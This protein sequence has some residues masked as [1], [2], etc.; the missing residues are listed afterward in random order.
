M[1]SGLFWSL[2]ILDLTEDFLSHYWIRRAYLPMTMKMCFYLVPSSTLRGRWSRL[3]KLS[4]LCLA[5][6]ICLCNHAGNIARGQDQ[7]LQSKLGKMMMMANEAEKQGNYEE[8]LGLYQKVLEQ[9]PEAFG[10]NSERE[11]AVRNNIAF[12]QSRLGQFANARKTYEDAIVFAESAFGKESP[13]LNSI[14][15]GLAGTQKQA[16]EYEKAEQSLNRVI[17]I[18][19]IGEPKDSKSLAYA[20]NNLADLK[21]LQGDIEGANLYYRESVSSAELAFGKDSDS[22]LEAI[23]E[24][25]KF[26]VNYGDL[27]A[28]VRELIRARD[29]VIKSEKPNLSLLV[30]LRQGLILADIKL[31]NLEAAEVSLVSLID[32]LKKILPVGTPDIVELQIQLAMV[33]KNLKDYEGSEFVIRQAIREMKENG[34][35]KQLALPMVRALS[36]LSDNLSKQGNRTDAQAALVEAISIDRELLPNSKKRSELQWNLNYFKLLDG[37]YAEVEKPIVELH[38][39]FTSNLGPDHP[40]SNSIANAVA[41]AFHGQKKMEEASAWYHRSRQSNFRDLQESLFAQPE[42]LQ[43]ALFENQDKEFLSRTLQFASEAPDNQAIQQRAVEWLANSKG[44]I[45]AVRGRFTEIVRDSVSVEISKTAAII[46][47]NRR[48][49]TAARLAEIAATTDEARLERHNEA[50][51]LERENQSLI[52]RIRGM[53]SDQQKTIPWLSYKDIQ[54]SLGTDRCLI[55]MVKVYSLAP[56]DE[57]TTKTRFMV[58]VTD[59][60][61]TST[62]DLGPSEEIELLTKKVAEQL[63]SAK[64]E[65][66]KLGDQVAERKLQE[67]LKN[68]SSRLLDPIA[69]RIQSSKRWEISLDAELWQIPWAALQ[70]PDGSYAIESHDIEIL[71]GARSLV[72]T[73]RNRVKPSR[74]VLFADPDFGAQA[75]SQSESEDLRGFVVDLNLGFLKELSGTMRDARALAEA[76]TTRAKTEKPIVYAE[77]L[78]TAS[79]FFQIRNPRYLLVAT[80]GFSIPYKGGT[81][82]AADASK[83]IGSGKFEKGNLG[84]LGDPLLRCGLLFAGCNQESGLDVEAMVTARDVLTLDL[85][86][87]EFVLL[88]SCES[89]VGEYRYGAGIASLRQAFLLAGASSVISTQWSISDRYTGLLVESF[90]KELERTGDQVKALAF[91]QR[92]MIRRL[93][94]NKQGS[95]PFYW[96]AFS[97]T[98]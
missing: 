98:R 75:S 73:K 39:E 92:E 18:A 13:K 58:W 52:L 87:C 1:D 44:M 30:R 90:S 26:L 28:A 70:L 72:S 25:G 88:S 22:H 32:D 85:R 20:N 14:L 42:A 19:S 46:D 34:D 65:I 40:L 7:A 3:N 33:R 79:N 81:L 54:N 94:E 69:D 82:D 4:Y 67:S 31:F 61:G 35:I 77:Q 29:I 56:N 50:I 12:V 60:N 78:A 68:L 38:K 6:W 63:S 91:A 51:R 97:V 45:E 16:G 23:I 43:W 49:I 24:Y 48:R 66:D 27:E 80:H 84:S 8:Q 83:L 2:L 96:A 5:C 47:E 37:K 21:T 17:Q 55:D 41:R 89:G 53:L 86:G 76:L 71:T 10:K 64:A 93:K 15:I 9:I 62:Y 11:V 36:E 57:T 59:Q 74:P 95:H